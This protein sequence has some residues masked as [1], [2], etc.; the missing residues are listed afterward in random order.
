MSDAQMSFLHT[1]V[2]GFRIM[3]N[4]TIHILALFPSTW[5]VA[6]AVSMIACHPRYSWSEK[7]TTQ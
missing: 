5:I 3:I 1:I 4:T 7:N 6:S 2:Y